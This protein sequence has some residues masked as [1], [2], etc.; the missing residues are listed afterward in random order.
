MLGIKEGENDDFGVRLNSDN[1]E[2]H[3]SVIRKKRLDYV[4]IHQDDIDEIQQLVD[5]EDPIEVHQ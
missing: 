4:R 2:K 5:A 1:I 3:L